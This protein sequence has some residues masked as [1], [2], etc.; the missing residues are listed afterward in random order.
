M[1]LEL[2][3]IIMEINTLESGWMIRSAAE[4]HITIT[5]QET[6]MRES[7]MII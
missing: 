3:F 1:E 6:C 2:T 4:E 7:G 5:T